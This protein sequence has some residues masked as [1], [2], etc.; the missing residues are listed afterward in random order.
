MWQV[1]ND[2]CIMSAIDLHNVVY[3]KMTFVY[4]DGYFTP[5]KL[6]YSIQYKNKLSNNHAKPKHY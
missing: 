3:I 2:V 5:D 6:Y 4:I 1:A